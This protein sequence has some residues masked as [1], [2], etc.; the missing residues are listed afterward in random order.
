MRYSPN[1]IYTFKTLGG[2]EVVSTCLNSDR[3]DVAWI[4]KVDLLKFTGTIKELLLDF[5]SNP[6]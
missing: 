6:T 4:C 1:N 3:E 5:A 2:V